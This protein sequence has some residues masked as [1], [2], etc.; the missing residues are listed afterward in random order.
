MGVMSLRRW[1]FGTRDRSSKG[2][3]ADP[4][5]VRITGSTGGVT[6]PLVK[7]SGT[8]THGAQAVSALAEGR[9]IVGR[10]M[11]QED[12]ILQREPDNPVDGWAVA[13]RVEG[14]RIGYLPSYAA[15][16]LQIDAGAG[17]VVPTQMFF[18]DQP[19]GV[20]GEEWVWLG[21]GP[22][23][24]AFSESSPPP[25]TTAEKRADQHQQRQQMVAD[26]IAAGG[27][28]A[29]QVRVVVPVGAA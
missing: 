21:D 6:S 19:G 14:E 16:E 8:T 3:S 22:A 15:Q 27:D 7:I 2:V 17:V 28:R 4:L 29:A 10:G 12:A 20:R 1:L 23:Q 25:L 26:A 5:A 24:W 11:L 18:V 13:V 9:Q